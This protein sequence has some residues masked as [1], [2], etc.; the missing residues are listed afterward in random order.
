MCVIIYLKPK[1][2]MPFDMLKN[3]CHN[4]WHSYGIV[5]KLDDGLD[6]KRVLPETDD[7]YCGEVDAEEVFKH[8][9]DDVDYPRFLHLRHNTAGATSIENTHPF[10]VYYKGGKNGRQVVFM[11]NGTLYDYKSKKLNA[12]GASVDDPD[13]KSDTAN[14]V[15]E[16]LTPLLASTNFGNGNGDIEND[17]I[18]KTIRKY[19]S[20]ANR[21]VLI[22]S[23]Q[24]PLFID[25]WKTVGPEGDK[26][27]AS[28]DDYFDEVKRGPEHARRLAQE[29]REKAA[30]EAVATSPVRSGPKEIVKMQDYNFDT[31]QKFFTLSG[32]L[33]NICNDWDVYDRPHTVALGYAT[34]DEL[35]KLYAVKDECLYIMDYIFTDYAQLYK[36]HLEL[37]ERHKKASKH[38][39]KLMLQLGTIEKKKK[40]G[41]AA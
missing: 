41:R 25:A 17:F 6:I 30:R 35:E 8:L 13:G 12:M 19:W 11:H 31:T 16:V 21:G 38:I 36:E 33:R 39:E 27:L 5:T 23:N 10:D 26:F 2:M 29:A 15:E 34:R 32:S 7:G 28:N 9:Q 18:A 20:S 40:K 1:Q 24:E 37:E 3:A 14:F 4:N 22:S